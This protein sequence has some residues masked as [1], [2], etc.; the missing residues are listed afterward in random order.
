MMKDQ[1]LRNTIVNFDHRAHR[2]SRYI[3]IG[4]VVIIGLLLSILPDYLSIGPSWIVLLV[5]A[6]LFIP[7]FISVLRGHHETTRKVAL[8]ILGVI[9]VGLISSVIFLILRLYSHTIEAST[10]F[11]NA[12][13]L[14]VSNVSVFSLWY[15]EVDQGGPVFRQMN[16]NQPTDFLFPQMI[17]ESKLWDHWK[18]KLM[19]YLFLA[20]NTSTAFSP[21]DT[22]IMSRRAK[23]L[24]MIQ[25]SISLVVIAVLA[26][27]AINIA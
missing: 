17:S 13:I 27:R 25:G 1:E 7:L 4:T 11:R 21:T 16:P 2:I 20:F 8:S 9:T 3:F 26:A 6:I 14:W 5:A 19:D 12:S 18:P 10:L 22:M 15:W 24:M 23:L